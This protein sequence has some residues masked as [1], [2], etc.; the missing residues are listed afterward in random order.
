MKYGRWATFVD[1]DLVCACRSRGTCILEWRGG[2]YI[3]IYSATSYTSDFL[4]KMPARPLTPDE[5]AELALEMVVG[6]A[7]NLD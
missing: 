7:A 5:E 6:G 3:C 4:R 2:Y 1:Q